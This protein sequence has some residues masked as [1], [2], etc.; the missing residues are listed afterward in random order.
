MNHFSNNNNL[1]FIIFIL[2]INSEVDLK[3]FK[4]CTLYLMEKYP[5]TI[6]KKKFS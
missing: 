2:K 4:R 5:K 3:K 1:K 6:W